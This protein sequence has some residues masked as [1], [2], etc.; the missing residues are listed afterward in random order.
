[1]SGGNK[2]S[3]YRIVGG[4]LEIAAS[5][6][7]T[8]FFRIRANAAPAQ[9]IT[10]LAPTTQPASSVDQ[11]IVINGTQAAGYQITF[12]NKPTG[13][14]GGEANTAS[15]PSTAPGAVSVFWRK[16]GTDLQFNKLL[17]LDNVNEQVANGVSVAAGID[18]A[19]FKVDRRLKQ[20]AAFATPATSK[21][22]QI[23]TAGT[24]TFFD[25]PGN[26]TTSIDGYLSAADKTKLNG[27][28]AG[29]TA[30]A[31]DTQ[32]RDRSTHTGTQAW[33]TITG[34][35]SFQASNDRLTALAGFAN[36]TT[37]KLT[38]VD[39]DG[40]LTLVDPPS[41]FNPGSQAANVF[42]ASPNG[43]TGNPLF[44]ALAWGD[45]SGLVGTS[46]SSFAVGNDARFHNRNQDTGTTSTT[47]TLDSGGTP[48]LL[49]DVA[50]GLQL[51][52]G[53]DNDNADFTAK[54]VTVSGNLTVTG[55][56][57]F[58][59]PETVQIQDNIIQINSDF[60]AGTPTQDL[61][62]EA[63]R[64]N[65]ASAQVLWSETAQRWQMGSVGN[66][67]SV[68]RFI[69]GTFAN[70]NLTAGILTVN[71]NLGRLRPIVSICDGNND[72]W[73]SVD[74]IKYISVNQLQVDMTSLGTLTGTW[75]ISIAG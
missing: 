10:L 75:G 37:V 26:A 24:M 1:M 55:A 68:A 56:T 73:S 67:L 38:Q 22:M 44:R 31:T 4:A 47:F 12:E 34:V 11:I 48:L 42:Y 41:G 27:I 9:N 69:E 70:A 19:D 20:I 13:T 6:A 74:N 50:G 66:M 18:T 52:N 8:A 16:L 57:T 32:L 3:S 62:I 60:T 30:N 15:S 43:A 29:A 72:V 65:S 49:K 17:F 14:G 46:G 36:P 40:V 5:L 59:Q 23:N 58:V 2:G 51:R 39:T 28:A 33:S 53:G 64:G 63:F 25:P 45:V 54:N 21:W 71:H 61:G 7:A 35:P